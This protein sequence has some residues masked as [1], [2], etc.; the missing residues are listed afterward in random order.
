MAVDRQKS[1][2]HPLS[3]LPRMPNEAYSGDDRPNFLTA[4][5]EVQTITSLCEF[6]ELARSPESTI[7]GTCAQVHIALTSLDTPVGDLNYRKYL[8]RE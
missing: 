6:P 7:S 8:P 4:E 3:S 1:I 2:V 5:W